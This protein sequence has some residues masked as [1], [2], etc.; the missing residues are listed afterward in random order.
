MSAAKWFH[1]AEEEIEVAIP[2]VIVDDE[3]DL[4]RPSRSQSISHGNH[5]LWRI[6]KVAVPLA[7]LA[8]F[9]VPSAS[10][11]VVALADIGAITGGAAASHLVYLVFLSEIGDKTFFVAA[12]LAAKLSRVISFVG[13]LGALAVMTIISVVIGQVFH[14]VPS[15]LSNGLPLDDVAA[16]IAF[17][18]FGVKILSEAFEEDEGKSAMDEEFEEAQ[19]V[20]QENDMTNSNA[21]AQIASIFGLVFAAE[22]G[23]RS[24][25]ATIALSAAQNPVSVAAGGIAAHGIA[26][27]IAVI[28]GA[29]ISKYVSEKVIAIIGGTLFIIFAITTAVGIF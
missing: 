25:L 24:F 14:A 2:E 15:E 29:Y 18:Y 17:T 11:A 22:F 6:T 4:R 8:V 13:S 5:H 20:V 19:E 27:G 28:G 3:L 12:L 10:N 1:H 26:T 16:V 9:T 23:D 21:G 7:A